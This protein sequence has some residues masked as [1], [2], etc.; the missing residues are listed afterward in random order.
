MTN[1]FIVRNVPFNPLNMGNAWVLAALALLV[2]GLAI[3]S[4]SAGTLHKSAEVTNVG[5]Y[6]LVRNPLYIGSFMMMFAFC[7]LCRDVPTL[8]FI[9]GPMSVLY[10]FQ[11]RFEEK[12]LLQLF[13]DQWP[14]YEASV[15]RIIPRMISR[16]TFQGW[17]A[18]EWLK[19]REYQALF[20]SMLGLALVYMWYTLV[21]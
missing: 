1:V 16:S 21:A 6:S 20:A 3:R 2:I 13:P 10:W 17:S 8:I 14:G 7:I 18:S 11:I 4:W 19:N 9:I 12:R 15:P 5:P